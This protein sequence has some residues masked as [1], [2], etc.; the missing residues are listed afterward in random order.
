M[1]DPEEVA[2]LRRAIGERVA[3]DRRLFDDVRADVQTLKRA[4]RAVKPRSVTAVSLV[5]S[6]GG[7]NA[8]DFDPF[9]LQVV[10]IVDSY[11]KKLL[12][13]VVSAGTDPEELGKAQFHA[14]GRPRTAL[15]VMMRDLGVS[16]L[17]ELSPMIPS[18]EDFRRGDREISPSWVLV[19]RELA[20]WAVL[21][22]LICHSE[23]GSDT[24]IVRDGLLRAKIF[25]GGLL[26]KWRDNVKAA[27]AKAAAESHRDIFLVGIAKRSNV[28]DRYNLAI[29]AEKL[30]PAG[31]A[32]YVRVPREMEAKAYQWPEWARGVETEGSG[33]E[34]PKFNIGDLY[35]VRF[36][37]RLGDPIWAVDL[38][39]DQ[40]DKASII[41][42]YLLA[43][44]LDGFPVPYYPR[45]LQR[46]HEHAQLG[47][48][49]FDLLQEG[50]FESI[51]ALLPPGREEAVD[52]IRFRA[53]LLAGRYQQ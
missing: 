38:F 36:G 15:G 24:L 2:E 47:G 46:A 49:D 8:V 32:Y 21:Y 4:I 50:V 39:S 18:S 28:I 45:C 27:I 5:A 20:E 51:R 40:S 12:T 33:G 1:F 43:D 22:N 9:H 23:F 16:T 30:F 48:F 7:N 37:A 13:E 34:G 42:G 10:R 52:E 41:F 19:F 53:D 14:D 6:D 3:A 17:N 35:L 25:S 44:A 31:E 11:G 29:A 26:M